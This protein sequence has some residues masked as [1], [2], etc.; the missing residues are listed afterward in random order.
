[1]ARLKE[2]VRIS[3]QNVLFINKQCRWVRI[4][5]ENAS[6]LSKGS[7][8]LRFVMDHRQCGQVPTNI[9][10]TICFTSCLE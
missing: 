8:A 2:A 10:S 7:K 4:A 9:S 3:K 1:M 5:N 6:K